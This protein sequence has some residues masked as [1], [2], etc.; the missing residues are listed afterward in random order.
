MP[1]QERREHEGHGENVLIAAH[2]CHQAR[3]QTQAREVEPREDT[4][5]DAGEAGD[6]HHEERHRA[7]KE[8]EIQD[9][10][11][12]PVERI[13]RAKEE[14]IETLRYRPIERG[15]GIGQKIDSGVAFPPEGQEVM[16]VPEISKREARDGKHDSDQS[17]KKRPPTG[18]RPKS[19]GARL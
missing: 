18:G 4:R 9:V 5:L 11:D 14:E 8:A 19:H 6:E 12:C 17:W 10:S 7:G 2:P 3:Y 13:D 16:V 1:Q 15:G